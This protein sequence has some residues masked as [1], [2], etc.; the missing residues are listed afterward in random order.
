[1]R[2]RAADYSPVLI[3]KAAMTGAGKSFVGRPH[4]ASKVGTGKADRLK[5]IGAVDQN[6]FCLCQHGS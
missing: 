1:M 6:R 5:T 3:K 2:C 4:L